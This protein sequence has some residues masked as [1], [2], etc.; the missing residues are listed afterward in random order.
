MADFGVRAVASEGAFAVS[1]TFLAAFDR[2]RNLS[3]ENVIERDV[4]ASAVVALLANQMEWRGTATG[5]LRILS[6]RTEEAARRSHVFPQ[7]A[8][9]LSGSLKRLATPLR[10]FGIEI[11]THR[12]GHYRQRV[13]TLKRTNVDSSASVATEQGAGRESSRSDGNA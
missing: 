2:N 7:T 5:L 13:I 3:I 10:A 1:G 11:E 9:H 6:T 4:V 8:S 12:E